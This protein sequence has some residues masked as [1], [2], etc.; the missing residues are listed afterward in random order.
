MSGMSSAEASSAALPFDWMNACRFASQKLREDVL[1]DLVAHVVPADHR[2]GKRALLREADRAVDRHP[3]QDA[4]VQELPPPAADLPDALVG[5]PP[6]RD[7]PN[8]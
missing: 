2:R 6:V 8:R 7:T 3:A 5:L 4:R 1:V